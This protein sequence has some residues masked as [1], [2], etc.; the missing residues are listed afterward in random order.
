MTEVQVFSRLGTFYSHL[1]NIF[2]IM[3][4][5]Q[6]FSDLELFTHEPNLTTNYIMGREYPAPKPSMDTPWKKIEKILSVGFSDT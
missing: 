6:V 3:T 4:E 2:A 5:V 1:N